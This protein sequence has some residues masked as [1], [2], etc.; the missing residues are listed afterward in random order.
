MNTIETHVLE[1]IGENT[2]S[3][4][5]F[6]DTDAGMEPIR[7]SINDAIEEILLFSGSM[8]QQYYISLRQDRTFY[9][10]VFTHG[11]IAWV[12]DVWL[13]EQKRRLEQTSLI[14]LIH[15]N[16][17]WLYN[18]GSPRAYFPI[19][20][21]Y[22]GIHP[23]PSSDTDLLEITA[24]M[25]PERYTKDTDKI[26]LR[27]SWEWA[28]AHYAVGEFYASRGDAKSAILHHNSYLKRTGLNFQYPSSNERDWTLS[29]NSNPWPKA[30]G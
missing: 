10:F 17:R 30:T 15:H 12:T 5:V 1:L 11:Y 7:D 24:V 20:F 13:L 23:K 2:D 19:G 26:N 21:N 6:L 4:D 3:P 16:P 27:N 8:K 14:K 22:F 9:R 29:S 18:T 28:A 25:I